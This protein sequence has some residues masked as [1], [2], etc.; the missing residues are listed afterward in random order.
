[1]SFA[2]VYFSLVI[3]FAAMY[4]GIAAMH[5]ECINSGGKMIGT[6]EGTRIFGD[7][8]HLSWTTFATVVSMCFYYF[9]PM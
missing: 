5:P 3:I 6:G 4:T 8:F 9:P 7:C 2:L 1:M